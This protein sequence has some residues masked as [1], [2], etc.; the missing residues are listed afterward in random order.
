MGMI[1]G[2]KVIVGSVVAMMLVGAVFGVLIG[3]LVGNYLITVPV[4]A[5]LGANFGLALAY[6]FLPEAPADLDADPSN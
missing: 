5:F 2:L 6:G 3:S 1:S 4:L